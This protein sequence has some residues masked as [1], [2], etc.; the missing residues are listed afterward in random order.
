M[1]AGMGCDLRAWWKRENECY[2]KQNCRVAK[3]VIYMKKYKEGREKTDLSSKESASSGECGETGL[4]EEP[5]LQI[6]RRRGAATKVGPFADTLCFAI[7]GE[8]WACCDFAKTLS[9]HAAR[10]RTVTSLFT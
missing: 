9:Q 5:A 6:Q 4:G 2:D 8:D 7:L 10:L 3:L 1:E